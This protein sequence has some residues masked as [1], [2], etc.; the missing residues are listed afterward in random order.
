MKS[1]DRIDIN[2]KWAIP[3][4]IP[5][6]LLIAAVMGLV[7]SRCSHK[8]QDEYFVFSDIVVKMAT[9][10]NIDVNFTVFN[11]TKINF[12]KKAIL[13]RVFDHGDEEIASKLTT[14]TLG[15]GE[16][17]RFIKVLTKFRIPINGAEDIS[18]VTV[19][20]YHASIF[21]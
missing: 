10:A 21:N 7:I 15:A 6:L 3:N 8:A 2:R 18:R 17:K 16:Q 14:I 9:H 11:R 5:M 12:E 4:W 13:I 20:M 1:V 19:E